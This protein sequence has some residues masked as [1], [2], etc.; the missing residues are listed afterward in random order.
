MKVRMHPIQLNY[1]DDG[2]VVVCGLCQEISAPKNPSTPARV[3]H[4][5]HLVKAH[6]KD[7]EHAN[8]RKGVTEEVEVEL[9]EVFQ[10]VEG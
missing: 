9:G 5:V 6:L 8:S 4:M 10:N 3:T 1:Q 7:V 2:D